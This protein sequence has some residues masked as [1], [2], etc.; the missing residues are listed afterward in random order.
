MMIMIL[1]GAADEW[2]VHSRKLD[3]ISCDNMSVQL[4]AKIDVHILFLSAEL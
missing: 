3:I 2:E 1:S 4:S